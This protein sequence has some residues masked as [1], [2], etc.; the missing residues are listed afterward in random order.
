M[1]QDDFATMFVMNDITDKINSMRQMEEISSYKDLLLATVTHDLKTP[2]IAVISYDQIL[3][4]EIRSN[5]TQHALEY[6][7]IIENNSV[8]LQNLIMDIQDL[9]QIK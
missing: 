7:E 1:W 6:L 8:L 5:S 3:Q 9:S 4:K 2:L